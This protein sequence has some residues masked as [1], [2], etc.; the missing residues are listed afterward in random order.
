MLI[1]R[2]LQL[3]F[4]LDFWE[5][6]WERGVVN[7]LEGKGCRSAVSGTGNL[8][9]EVGGRSEIK[10]RLIFRSDRLIGVPRN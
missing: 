7:Y 1:H 2:I 5:S 8:F 3:A 6:E 4:Y 10:L 9:L